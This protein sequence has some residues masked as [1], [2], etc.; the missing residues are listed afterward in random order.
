MA[1]IQLKLYSAAL[2]TRTNVNVIIPTLLPEVQRSAEKGQVY[3]DYYETHGDYPVLYLLHGTFG[4]EGDWQRFSRIEDYARMHNVA[5]VMPYAE[6]SCYKDLQSGKNYET[7][8]TQELPK[9]IQWMF[10]VS[11]KREDTFICGLSMGGGGAIR[12]GLAHPDKFGYAIG[13]SSDI[14]GIQERTQNNGTYKNFLELAQKAS[15]SPGESPKLYIACGTE[16]FTYQENENFHNY[17]DK[18]G[19]EHVFA[20]RPGTHNWDYWDIEI[21]NVLAWLKLEE[22]SRKNGF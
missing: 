12:L 9:I 5:V 13:M 4:D 7:Y 15:E 3:A 16:D 2:K 8:I 14:G 20:T 11:K 19:Y 22:K 1:S 10:P 17:L 6:N 18:I 21:R